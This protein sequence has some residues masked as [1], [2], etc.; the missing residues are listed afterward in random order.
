MSVNSFDDY[1]M[2]WKPVLEE[3]RDQPIYSYLADLLKKDI[4]EGT[5]TPGT[6]LPPQ[7]ELADFLDIN[8][9][10]ITRAFRLCEQRGLL[11]SVKG[12]GTFVSS[13]A[14]KQG[15]LMLHPSEKSLIQMGP[16]LP[17]PDIGESATAYLQMMAKEPDF[18]KLLQYAST[19]YDDLQLRAVKRWMRYLHMD[20]ENENILFSAGS[21]N[22]IFA[23]LAAL[24][25]EGDKIATTNVIYPGLKTAAKIL[26]IK[27]I[28]FPLFQGKITRESLEYVYKNAGVN[29]FYLIPDFN[30]PSC[31][32][33][34]V[35]TR[36]M[37]GEFCQEKQITCMEDCIY[38]LFQPDTLPTIASFAPDYG[39]VIASVS[40]IMSPGL[41]LAVMHVPAQFREMIAETLYAMEI[42]P[43]G[44]MMQLFTRLVNSGRF[45]V[46][47]QMR[48]EEL[49]ERNQLFNQYCGN[50]T[51]K[52]NRYCPVRWVLLENNDRRTPA[53]FEKEAAKQGINVYGAERFVVGNSEIPRA[54]RVSLISERGEERFVEGLIRLAELIEGK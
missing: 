50:V 53:Q 28:P 1:P 29:G 23:T 54:I 14:A 49:V 26:G 20:S 8:L 21:Q 12:S 17:N 15:M 27:V 48:I 39:I 47:R 19:E 7:R 5:L 36:R 13:D 25:K 42:T 38:T 43:P 9:S 22:A 51:S 11:C 3:K 6:K 34:N 45:D 40:K 52:G 30:N 44:L 18:Y 2:T 41:R 33:M 32:L 24:Y 37:I 46:I 35:E 4:M 31:E 16:I 10:T